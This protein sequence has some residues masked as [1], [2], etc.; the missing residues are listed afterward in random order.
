MKTKLQIASQVAAD[1]NFREYVAQEIYFSMVAESS[2]FGLLKTEEETEEE[3]A[4]AARYAAT[5]AV[6]LEEALADLE[7]IDE[8]VESDLIEDAADEPETA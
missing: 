3:L 6:A 4:I 2:N 1:M 8:T 7:I 5:A